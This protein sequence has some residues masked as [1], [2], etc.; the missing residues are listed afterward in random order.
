MHEFNSIHATEWLKY[1]YS[2]VHYHVHWRSV[3][4]AAKSYRSY[5]SILAHRLILDEQIRDK[6]SDS[7]KYLPKERNEKVWILNKRAVRT[8]RRSA[9]NY[10]VMISMMLLLAIM[11]LGNGKL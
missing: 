11:G 10:E 5:A 9:A 8:K 6:W 1:N 2:K 4:D 7:F 3:T